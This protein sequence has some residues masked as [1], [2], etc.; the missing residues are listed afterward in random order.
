MNG[1]PDISHLDTTQVD[2]VALYCGYDATD[3]CD[4]HHR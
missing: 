2:T 4:H 3:V 1:E